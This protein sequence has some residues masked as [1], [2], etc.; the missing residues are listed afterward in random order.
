MCERRICE[1]R[2]RAVA[3][4]LEGRVTVDGVRAQKPGER[5]DTQCS[6]TLKNPDDEFVGRGA[7]KLLR[8]KER[9]GLDFSGRVCLDI[10]AS[11]G[12]FT[13]VMLR[14]GALKVISVDVGTGVLHPAIKNDPSVLAFERTNIRDFSLASA[15]VDTVDFITCD[16]SF[17][18][19]LKFRD[20]IIEFS[21]PGTEVVI[22]IKPQFEAEVREVKKGGIVMDPVI[23]KRIIGS[24]GD[25]FTRCGFKMHGLTNAP[26]LR[27]C[28]NIEYLIFMKK[29]D[30]MPSLEDGAPYGAGLEID[31]AISAAFAEFSGADQPVPTTVAIK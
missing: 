15:D 28:K 3:Y 11:T 26:K 14:G 2:N 13:Q 30:S 29:Y 16:V 17:I 1:S 5:H 27:D 18:S 4:I 12:G 23:H 8:A 10:G 25:E 7:Y 22:L 9:F 20:K 19:V 6:I 31:A 24:F 21:H